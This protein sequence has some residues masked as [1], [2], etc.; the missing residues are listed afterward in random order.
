MEAPYIEI[1]WILLI[2]VIFNAVTELI[3]AGILF[4]QKNVFF[5]VFITHA[6]LSFLFGYALYTLTSDFVS[7][8]LFNIGLI[9]IVFGLVNELSA[10]ML[11]SVKEP[12]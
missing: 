6:L 10:F 1:L 9:A 2:W 5:A 7:Q 11:H 12:K 8:K 3:E 4:F